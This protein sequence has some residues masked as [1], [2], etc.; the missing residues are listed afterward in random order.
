M[1]ANTNLVT[2]IIVCNIIPQA[3]VGSGQKQLY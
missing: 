3:R 2:T 1:Q